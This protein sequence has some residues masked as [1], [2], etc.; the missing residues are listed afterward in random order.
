MKYKFLAG[1]ILLIPVLFFVQQNIAEVSIRF[2]KWQQP[3]SLSLLL[4]GTLVGGFILGLIY[5]FLRRRKKDKKQKALQQ[6]PPTEKKK[7]KLR[8]VKK[9]EK[10]SDAPAQVDS[11]GE[12]NAEQNAT[13]DS[14]QQEQRPP[15]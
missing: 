7:S 4:L 2:Y 11:L 12:L 3:V 13:D 5:G 10:T 8:V 9:A 15:V 14:L 6:E 1:V